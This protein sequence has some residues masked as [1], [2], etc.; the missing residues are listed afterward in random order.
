[1]VQRKNTCFQIYIFTFQDITKKQK[2]E[3]IKLQM[4]NGTCRFTLCR[5]L[6]KTKLKCRCDVWK[7]TFPALENRSVS[8][9]QVL[10]S[11]CT[12]SA[13]HLIKADALV[14]FMSGGFRC[15]ESRHQQWFYFAVHQSG[16]SFKTIW[17]GKHS[18]VCQYSQKWTSQ[19]IHL[20]VRLQ[21][22]QEPPLVCQSI[23]E[24]RSSV[25]QVKFDQHWVIK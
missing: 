12:W 4:N 25:H 2:Q 7:Y 3:H 1:M 13:D 18:T 16:H 23:L 21:K 9:S 11:Q 10:L 24:S 17:R 5:Y 19:Q 20:K 6:T 8:S 14:V 15:E 22:A